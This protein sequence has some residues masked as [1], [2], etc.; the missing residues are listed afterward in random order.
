M[1]GA[2]RRGAGKDGVQGWCAMMSNRGWNERQNG[3]KEMRIV[4]KNAVGGK[5]VAQFQELLA[6]LT[7]QRDEQKREMESLPPGRLN[8]RR[9]GGDARKSG[10]T[11]SKGERGTIQYLQYLDGKRAGI[12]KN[13]DLVWKLARK[14]YLA[15]AMPLVEQNISAVKRLIQGYQDTNPQ[16][17]LDRL[18][19][20]YSRI[21]D[22]QEAQWIE[23]K[24]CWL[25]E[26]FDQSTFRTWEKDHVTAKGLWVRTKS[27]VI[28]AERLDYYGI[29]YRYEQMLY[30][31]NR[32]FAPDFT[33][34]TRNG[35]IYWEHAGKVND[36]QYMANHI[37]KLSYYHKAD[38]VPWKNL[39]VTY[40]RM[41]GGFDARII[42]AEI[43]N[44]VLPYC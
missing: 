19:V 37:W 43:I 15:A 22:A 1:I 42:E 34:L 35:L 25:A 16:A 36:G 33:I 44:K 18:P 9:I 13:R 20:E 40:D 4:W 12:T 14:E 28:V 26:D 23:K 3:K 8:M 6:Q 39:I 21:I 17:I 5:E 2:L 10:R 38:I 41:E 32:D 7:F 31:E 30:I 29:P 27:E 24:R 11:K